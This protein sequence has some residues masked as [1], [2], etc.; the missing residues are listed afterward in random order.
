M[1]S[2][3]GGAVSAD[4]LVAPLNAPR[5][6]PLRIAVYNAVA[7]A[8]RSK[9]LLPGQLLPPESDLG[10]AFRISRTVMRE[11]LILLE[12]DG[13]IR[14]R[15]GIG[16][17]VVDVL[18]KI[19]IERL[20]PL[21]ELFNRAD[22]LVRVERLRIATARVT[23]FTMHGLALGPNANVV[24][25][26]SVLFDD[27]QPVALIQEWIPTDADRAS[28]APAIETFLADDANEHASMLGVLQR[29]LEENLDRGSCEIT[30]S[31][32]GAHRAQPLKVTDASPV[33]LLT[34]TVRLE[35]VPFLLAKY[36]IRPEFAHIT[37][38]Q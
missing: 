11:A 25:W 4:T 20:R 14:T 8:I 6:L 7:E 24:V 29:A 12:E 19:G 21:E 33:M 2:R 34:Q 38:V 36:T 16:R 35:D 9:Q 26:E 5:H 27:G 15:R 18:P 31:N 32:A 13:L 10:A 3:P 37:V 23:D 22:G 1:V 30:V 28:A 17:F